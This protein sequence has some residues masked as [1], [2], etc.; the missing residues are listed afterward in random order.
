MILQSPFATEFEISFELFQL[1]AQGIL[2]I[3]VQE[4]L[5]GTYGLINLDA[6]NNLLV[7]TL[8]ILTLDSSLLRQLR[9]LALIVYK[10]F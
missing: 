6:E 5:I 10:T 2:T 4:H 8:G 1:Q 3:K 7:S 9:L